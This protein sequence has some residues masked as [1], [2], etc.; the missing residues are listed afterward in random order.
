MD[1]NQV[2]EMTYK[3]HNTWL[4]QVSYNFTNNKDKARELVQDLYVK[5]LEFKNINKIM[6][7]QDVNLFYLYKMLTSIHLNGIKKI[8][9]VLPI[10]DDLLNKP[11]DSYSYEADNE[12]ERMVELTHEALDK[13]YWF[14]KKL[15]E[16]YINEDHSIQSLHDAT[17]ISNSTI[18]T[19]LNKTKNS[20]REY[21]NKNM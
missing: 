10:D 5:L 3:R 11:A 9:N 8:V 15:L 13:E 16:V 17:C 20:V 19:Q 7:K 1:N 2:V 6:Y 4:L 18:W 14:G 21:V 12:F